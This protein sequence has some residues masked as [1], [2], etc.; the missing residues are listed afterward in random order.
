VIVDVDGDDH[1]EIVVMDN[2]YAFKICDQDTGGGASHTGFKVYG[3]TLDRWVRTRRIWN[4]HAYHVTNVGDDGTIPKVEASNWAQKGLNN[5]RQN[6]QTKNVLNAPDLVPRD[7][8]AVVDKCAKNTMTAVATVFNRGAST[9]P[10]GVPVSFYR[11]TANGPILLGTAHTQAPTL[12]GAGETL[13]LDFPLPND[14]P[15]PRGPFAILVVVDD[16]GMPGTGI[17]NDGGLSQD[18]LA[19]S[20]P[21]I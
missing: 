7:L 12:A 2:N 8:H 10:A 11:S 16:A 17:V 20:P 1:A 14:I 13:S 4:Q 9:A 15:D 6:V 19:Q 21:V 3:D 5:F 18:R